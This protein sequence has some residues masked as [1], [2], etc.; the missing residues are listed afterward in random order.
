M[1]DVRASRLKRNTNRAHV[2]YFALH[3]LLLLCG[4]VI[5]SMWPVCC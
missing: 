2:F 5:Y 1:L 4:G 3:Y